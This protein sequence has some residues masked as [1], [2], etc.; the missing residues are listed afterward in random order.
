MVSGHR[1][2]AK[3]TGPA[4]CDVEEGDLRRGVQADGGPGGSKAAI[5][6]FEEKLRI[7]LRPNQQCQDDRPNQDESYREGHRLQEVHSGEEWTEHELHDN[8]IP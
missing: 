3:L 7:W 4:L 2:L 5:H 6:L 8:T 1:L